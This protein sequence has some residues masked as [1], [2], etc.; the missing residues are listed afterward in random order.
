MQ[1]RDEELEKSKIQQD[2]QARRSRWPLLRACLG[3]ELLV[4]CL[5]L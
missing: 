3:R 5:K 4:C 2:L 1:I